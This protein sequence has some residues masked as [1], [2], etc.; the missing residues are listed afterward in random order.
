MFVFNSRSRINDLSLLQRYTIQ[1]QWT[2]DNFANAVQTIT[3]SNFMVLIDT[4]IAFP[5]AMNM[6][7]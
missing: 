3:V 1:W 7:E 2:R 4:F 6:S 5:L